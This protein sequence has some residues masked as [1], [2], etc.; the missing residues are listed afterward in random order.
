MARTIQELLEIA[1]KEDASD[2]HITT[3]I[4]P[5]VRVHGVLKSVDQP[6]LPPAETKQL[7]YSVINDRQ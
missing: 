7:I 3:Y 5:R 1:V 6:P 2:L 4:P